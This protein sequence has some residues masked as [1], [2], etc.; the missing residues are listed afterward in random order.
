LGHCQIVYITNERKREYS[1]R[2]L[3]GC[4]V[5]QKI[6]Y[7]DAELTINASGNIMIAVT[8]LDGRPYIKKGGKDKTY[9]GTFRGGFG[10]PFDVSTESHKPLADDITSGICASLQKK[11]LT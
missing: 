8:S 11:G 4:A 10:N 1:D 3:G 2:L 9:I 6:R 7:H 5:A